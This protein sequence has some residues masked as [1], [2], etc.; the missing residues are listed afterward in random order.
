MIGRVLAVTTALTMATLACSGATV[1]VTS[2][3]DAT[4]ISDPSSELAL[5]A[6]YNIYA[7]RVGEN[8]L[9]T[10]RRGLLQFDLSAV[11]SGS[12]ITSV[13]LNLYLSAS[14]TGTQTVS[15]KKMLLSWGEGA[16]FAFGGGG[17]PAQAND[18]TW[19]N[20]FY[21]SQPWPVPGGSFSST[22]SASKSVAGIAWYTWGSTP[23]MVADVQG[24][25]DAPASNNG[26]ILLGN[27]ET[28]QAVKRFDARES[29]PNAPQL[30]I[31]YNP[32]T[33]NPSD[34]NNDGLVNGTDLAILLGAWNTANATADINNDRHVDG[35]DLALLLAGW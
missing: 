11:P 7:G 19:T 24:W 21:P 14:Q 26:W 25:L 18:A 1:M 2:V 27:E 31:T 30:I 9:G 10:L 32:P 29:G 5:G 33:G 6:A 17:A 16:S 13:Q 34:L 15:I 4:L 12:I 3:K 23:Q 8:G 20:R 35:T 22:L 28:L